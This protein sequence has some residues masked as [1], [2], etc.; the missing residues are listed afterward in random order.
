[1]QHKAGVIGDANL[2][3]LLNGSACADGGQGCIVG[4]QGVGA[5][6]DGKRGGGGKYHAKEREDFHVYRQHEEKITEIAVWVC[7]QPKPVFIYDLIVDA[8]GH[9]SAT[10][11]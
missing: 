5:E 2:L 1:M 9:S 7:V 11:T 4:E 10:V 3:K 8:F 6:C